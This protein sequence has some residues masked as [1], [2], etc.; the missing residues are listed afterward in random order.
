[1]RELCLALVLLTAGLAGCIGGDDAPVDASSA[2]S[3]KAALP[4]DLTMERGELVERNRTTAVWAWNGTISGAE[5]PVYDDSVGALAS[6]FEIPADTPVSLSIEFA[7]SETPGDIEVEVFD[8]E[9]E[10]WC[11]EDGP[12][13]RCA[14]YLAPRSEPETWQ[15]KLSPEGDVETSFDVTLT[16]RTLPPLPDTRP[17]GSLPLD[18][19]NAT[20]RGD[21]YVLWDGAELEPADGECTPSTC[22]RV[23]VNLTQPVP[24]PLTISIEWEGQD[25]D[26]DEP[27]VANY[28]GATRLRMSLEVHRN[29]KLLVDGSESSH[30]AA[31]AVIEAPRPGTYEVLVRGERGT[32]TYMGAATLGDAP[33]HEAVSPTGE[34]HEDEAVPDLVMLPPDH[35]QISTPVPRSTEPVNDRTNPGCGPDET[36]EDQHRRCLRFA[37]ILG[38]QGNGPFELRLGVEEA[39]TQIA[40]G[41]DW[42]QAIYDEDDEIARRLSAGPANYHPVHGHFHLRALVDTQLYPIDKNG[43]R[44]EPIGPGQ[45]TGFCIIDGGLIDARQPGATPYAYDGRGCCYIAG[46]CQLD[47]LYTDEF[48]MGMTEGWY[49]IY[50]WYRADQYLE[51]TGVE[52]GVY[53]LVSVINPNQQLL[54]LNAYNNE[55]STLIR[56]TGNEVEMLEQRTQADVGPHPDADWGYAAQQEEGG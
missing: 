52:D 23:L 38:N 25:E 37:G 21:S 36:L 42:D 7:R 49:D 14:G 15:V 24:G 29:G 55:A 3:P 31:T 34:I 46:T 20:E 4:D 16:L 26:W 48:T 17:E 12:E 5:D 32:G 19:E 45:K 33:R 18:V 9:G 50:P 44:G 27:D 47:M 10:R 6:A 51:I 56:I 35:V 30:Y 22:D 2:A 13:G 41:A 53:E 28:L 11:F 40:G 54:E 43:E 8:A 1:M 39:F